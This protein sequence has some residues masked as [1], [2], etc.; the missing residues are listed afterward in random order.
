MRERTVKRFI[1]AGSEREI[2]FVRG[3]TEA[4]NLVASFLWTIAFESR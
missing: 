2:I 4:I 3:T 1:N